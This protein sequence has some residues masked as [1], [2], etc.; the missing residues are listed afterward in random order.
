VTYTHRLRLDRLADH[1]HLVPAPQKTVVAQQHMG[2]PAI[3]ASPPTRAHPVLPA[4]P[5]PQHPQPTMTPR[6]QNPPAHRACQQSTQQIPL[7]DRPISPYHEH[8]CLPASSEGPSRRSGKNQREGPY[9]SKNTPQPDA[10]DYTPPADTTTV[11]PTLNDA[12][13]P[14]HPHSGWRST[15]YRRR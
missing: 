5:T 9:A 11:V 2:L 7:D 12:T 3:P 13:R 1:P 4:I 10:L 8:R 6:T 14:N 15:V